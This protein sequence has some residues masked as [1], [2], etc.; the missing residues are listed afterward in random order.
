M[1]SGV[2]PVVLAFLSYAIAWSAAGAQRVTSDT[3]DVL[4]RVATYV[5]QYYSR[6]QSIV[7]VETVTVQNVRRDL[8]ADGFPRRFVYNLRVDWSPSAAGPPEAQLTREL[9]TVNGRRPRED[10]EPHCTAPKAITPE[11]LAMFLRERQGEFIFDEPERTSLDRRPVLRLDY[12][13]RRPDDDKVEWDRDC[14]SMDFPARLHGR[15][16]ID[17][18]SGEVLRID[19]GANGPVE[20]ASPRE[21]QRSGVAAT[22]VFERWNVSI[23][24]K[25]VTFHDP[26][27][28][29][30]LPASIESLTMTRSNGTRR[31]Q[32]Y[33]HYRRYVTDGRV[34]N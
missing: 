20:I 5:E 16:W 6:A 33:A 31:T 23:R 4:G 10:E 28:R 25:R 2:R 34:I 8:G 24:Y 18:A 21:Q 22:M 12:R 17:E 26:D 32:T 1:V 29:I 9:V 3:A 7:A 27:E 30:L 15:V 13:V 11:P 19:E 14:V